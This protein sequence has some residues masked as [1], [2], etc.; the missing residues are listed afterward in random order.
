MGIVGVDLLAGIVLGIVLTLLKIIYLFTHLEIE[1]EPAIE[2]SDEHHIHLVGVATFLRLPLLADH[3]ET[4]APETELHV[5]FDKLSFIDH[6][7]LELLDSWEAQREKTGGKLVMEWHELHERFQNPKKPGRSTV[8]ELDTKEARQRR[9][10]SGIYPIIRMPEGEVD[11]TESRKDADA[12][13]ER[14]RVG[15][16]VADSKAD[17]PRE[18]EPEA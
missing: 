6:S 9:A 8:T 15:R 1:V 11:Q 4:L 2:G 16:V 17:K 7:C 14:D 18:D 13:A 3:L 12:V 5:H 10:A